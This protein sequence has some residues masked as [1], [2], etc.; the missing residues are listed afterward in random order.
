MRYYR[1]KYLVNNKWSTNK[2]S[3]LSLLLTYNKYASVPLSQESHLWSQ[4]ENKAEI[5]THNLV[6]FDDLSDLK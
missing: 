5:H 6:Y 2:C 4:E 1:H 3:L